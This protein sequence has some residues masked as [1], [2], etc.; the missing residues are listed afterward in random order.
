M[1]EMD[2]N[3]LLGTPECIVAVD[4]RIKIHKELRIKS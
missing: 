4:A 1:S 2:I 3:P